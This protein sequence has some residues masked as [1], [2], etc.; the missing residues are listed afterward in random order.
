MKNAL[1]V[2]EHALSYNRAFIDY[3]KR[4][5]IQHAGDLDTIHFIR[6][7]DDD[8]VLVLEEVVAAHRN[9]FI[10][11]SESFSFAGKIVATICH[12]GLV[13]REDMLIPRKAEQ[14]VKNSYL[15]KKGATAINVLKV[16]VSRK[17]P[18]ILIK[19]RREDIRFFL[20]DESK[21]K[22]IETAIMHLEMQFE[23]VML[24]E[25]LWF[26][27]V[28]GVHE[29]QLEHIEIELERIAADAILIGEDLS[30]II[31]R[32]LVEGEKSITT[33]ESCTG[34]MIASEIVRHSGVSAIFAGS[35]VSYANEVKQKELGVRESTLKRY[36]A[37]SKECVGEMLHG[38]MEKFGADFA[39]AVSGVAGPTGG[40]RQ[41]PVGT[42]Y[43]GAKCKGKEMIIRRLSLKGDRTYIR[44][45]SML[46]AFRLLLETNREFFFKKV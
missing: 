7:G 22:E 35:I 24:L 29:S 37:V 34:G 19:K 6:K 46:W 25:N 3:L 36:G 28:R 1:V 42:V 38:V 10:V 16:D 11:T 2:L 20:F 44:E 15:I 23:K 4:E 41:K 14:F 13:V 26:Y 18:Q 30:A 32:R 12:D 43:V 5:I 27:S 31:A 33:A 21:Q 39:L 17:I 9:V 8:I 40:T 45:I